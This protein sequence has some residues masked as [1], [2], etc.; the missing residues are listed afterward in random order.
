MQIGILETGVTPDELTADYGTYADMFQTMLRPHITGVEFT[1]F[2]VMNDQFPDDINEMDAW[3]VTGSKH[4]VY[5]ALPWMAPLQDFIRQLWQEKKVLVGICFGHQIIA[6][7]LG[8]KVEK[9]TKGWGIGQHEYHVQQTPVWMDQTVQLTL[10]AMH[11][12]QVVEKPD[13]AD[14]LASSEFCP[15]AALVYGDSILT[16]QPHP[17]FSAPFEC[18]LI[19]TRRPDIITDDLAVPAIDAMTQNPDRVDNARVA[20]WIANFLQQAR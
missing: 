6:A 12:D 19:E 5:D 1:V 7:A 10:H 20:Q 15:H 16:F 9:S 2:S 4:G 18:D 8:G 17:E 14:I 3:M 11:Q 13:C